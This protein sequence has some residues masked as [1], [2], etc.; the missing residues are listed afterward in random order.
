MR[1]GSDS[2]SATTSGTRAVMSSS[3]RV[4]TRTSSPSRCTCTRIPS[5]FHSTAAGL[6]FA[7]AS[8]TSVAVEASIGCTGRPTS[9]RNDDSAASPCCSTAVA[10][11]G[12]A[13]QSIAARRSAAVGTPAAF[14]AASATTLSSAPCRRSPPISPTSSRCSSAV[15][16]AEEVSQQARPLGLRT[17]AGAGRHR[18]E[19]GVD[20]EHGQRRDLVPGPAALAATGSPPRYAAAAARPTGSPRRPAPRHT[21]PPSGCRRAVRP[22][23]CAPTSRQPRLRSGRGRRRAPVS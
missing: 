18:L 20:V 11:G 19:G 13:P 22:C 12:S 21:P 14:A 15:A 8:A 16:A 6:I 3:V 9:S 23:R 17:R 5:S 10:T 2:A 7:S 4:K 1:T